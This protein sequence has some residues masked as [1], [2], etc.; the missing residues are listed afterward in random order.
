MV[1]EDTTITFE[2]AKQQL[3]LLQLSLLQETSTKTSQQY[4]DSAHR[5]LG[6]KHARLRKE[7]TAIITAETE[8]QRAANLE[9]LHTWCPDHVFL[10]ESL[11][12]LARVHR[13]V[14]AITD[15]GSRYSDVLSTFESWV[16]GA[17]D[18][19]IGGSN[20]FL[21]P[22]PSEW[23]EA[24]ASVALKVRSLQRELGA[25]PPLP[26]RTGAGL[27]ATS[28]ETLLHSC[29][30]LIDG[31][32]RELD[33]MHKL[34]KEMLAQEEARIDDAVSG[35]DLDGGKQAAWVPEWQSA[36]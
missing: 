27:G 22:L 13:D 7:L 34:E 18:T 17:E 15:P 24:H 5:K 33:M 20:T 36:T 11:Q 14:S 16:A 26:T 2:V 3:E 12:T 25:L 29:R 1:E 10:V 4:L 21:D 6:K 8:H 23:Q 32:P 28:L 9:V 35:M 30:T 19:T 31:I